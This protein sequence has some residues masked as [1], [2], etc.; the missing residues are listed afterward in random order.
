MSC[1]CS[2]G[3]DE[4]ATCCS[5]K[6][7]PMG[8]WIVVV[9]VA[10]LAGLIIYSKQ[11]A[12][13]QEAKDLSIGGLPTLVE[14]GSQKCVPCK[15]MKPIIQDLETNYKKSLNVVF[16]DVWENPEVGEKFKIQI[17]PIQIFLDKNGNEIFRHE[18]F[19]SKEEILLKWKEL[20]YKIEN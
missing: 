12:R 19:F 17:I 13:K 10:V 9:I 20:G 7:Y 15:M 5:K 16:Y 3:N 4:K 2:N 1:N 11:T 18:G 6:N 14:L 8:K